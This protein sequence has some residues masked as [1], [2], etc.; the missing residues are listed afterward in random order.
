MPVPLLI[1]PPPPGWELF[2]RH[3]EL[4]PAVDFTVSTPMADGWTFPE[5]LL[6]P[7][8]ALFG[9]ETENRS[10][11]FLAGLHG[12]NV[13]AARVVPA[14]GSRKIPLAWIAISLQ[15]QGRRLFEDLLGGC[16]VPGIPAIGRGKELLQAAGLAGGNA[17]EKAISE[18]GV[19]S[20][21]G[22]EFYFSFPYSESATGCE[23]VYI[24]DGAARRLHGFAL[25][26]CTLAQAIAK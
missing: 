3:T 20:P 2:L 7:I 22:S 16:W 18:F 10:E 26:S 12:E 13:L 25:P 8:T 11:N 15:S 4:T 23:R 9:I 6:T 19:P 17:L 5:S 1:A 14:G 21:V 24:L